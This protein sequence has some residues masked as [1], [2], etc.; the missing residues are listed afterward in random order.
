MFKEH[1]ETWHS[2]QVQK[3]SSYFF[4][5]HV[6]PE[7]KFLLILLFCNHKFATSPQPPNPNV[8]RWPTV[9]ANAGLW[10]FLSVTSVSSFSVI[11]VN[12]FSCLGSHPWGKWIH[13]DSL[14]K[15]FKRFV[16]VEVCLPGLDLHTLEGR[17][18]CYNPFQKQWN[19]MYTLKMF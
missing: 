9:T 10:G 6:L 14:R 18:N 19:H 3:K 16:G 1:R 7:M 8:Y 11:V 17:A 4:P 5:M 12:S 13:L 15:H 2:F